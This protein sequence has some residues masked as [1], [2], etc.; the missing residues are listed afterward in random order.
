MRVNAC[1]AY[2]VFGLLVWVG[3]VAFSL[4]GCSCT[5]SVSPTAETAAPTNHTN[6]TAAAT[7]SSPVAELGSSW[8]VALSLTIATAIC[9][10]APPIFL[11]IRYYGPYRCVLSI[12]RAAILAATTALLLIY[13]VKGESPPPKS[14][15]D[16]IPLGGALVAATLVIAVFFVLSGYGFYKNEARVKRDT[17]FQRDMFRQN[18]LPDRL[19]HQLPHQL[20]H[21]FF[22]HLHRHLPHHLPHHLPRHH[23]HHRDVYTNLI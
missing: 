18:Q 1:R 12:F 13:P 20:P 3:A 10:S 9:L 7:C 2:L 4:L 8:C 14:G 21:H 17:R 22:H 16:G 5:D 15:A 11:S 23:P 6:A 19:P